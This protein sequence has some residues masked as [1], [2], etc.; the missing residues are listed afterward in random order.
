APTVGLRGAAVV[1]HAQEGCPMFSS[2][3]SAVRTRR[4]TTVLCALAMSGALL[5][6]PAAIAPAAATA[7]PTAPAAADETAASAL[8]LSAAELVEGGALQVSYRTDAPHEQNW[9]GIYGA[10]DEVGPVPS[11]IWDY[12]PGAEGELEFTLDLAPGQYEVRFLAQDG[13][14]HLAGPYALTVTADPERPQPGDPTAPVGG[15]AV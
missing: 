11:R 12:A 6:T 7:A 13:Y 8:T 5:L 1:A 2:P 4:S 15:S 3:P 10:G 14:E 9:I